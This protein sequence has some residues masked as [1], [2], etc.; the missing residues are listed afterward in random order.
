LRSIYDPGWGMLSS[1]DAFIFVDNHDNQRGHGGAG[2][3]L[4]FKD[5]KK[6]KMAVAFTFAN[7]YG[8]PQVMISYNFTTDGQ[9][10]PSINGKTKDVLIRPDGSCGDGWICEHR[11]SVIA[12]MAGFSKAVSGT[13]L[14]NWWSQGGAIAFSRGNKGFFA[15]ASNSGLD[16]TIHTGLPAGSYCNVISG[17]PN[18]NGCSGDIVVV[19]SA[20]QAR[21]QIKNGNEPIFAIHVEAKANQN[22]NG[23][24]GGGSGGGKGF[25]KTAIFVK[26][27]SNNAQSLF[28]RGGIDDKVRQGCTNNVQTSK[29]AIDHRVLSVGTTNHFSMYNTWRAGDTKLDWFGREPTQHQSAEGTPLAWTTNN[30]GSP[31]YLARNKYGDHYWYAEF[32]INCDQ[33]QDGWFEVKGFLKNDN[34]VGSWEGHVRQQSCSGS[35]GS[36]KFPYNSN[37]HFAR[38]GFLNIFEYNSNSCVIENM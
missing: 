9:G 13:K 10:P 37:N 1:D 19:N 15:M 6:Y 12:A 21:I 3:V 25:Q 30:P 36:S 38:C 20:G 26:F 7:D 23:G 24:G 31:G 17:M 4:T 27:V 29:C 16:T 33:T 22:D 2:N 18:S 5:P 28:L 8:F 14:Q 34:G 35:G 32:E 11:W